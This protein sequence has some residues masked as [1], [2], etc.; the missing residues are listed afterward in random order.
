MKNLMT[1]DRGKAWFMPFDWGNT[2]LIYR[3]DK[4]SEEEAQSLRIF[5]DPKFRDRV[6][7]GDN[8]D[9]AYALASLVHRA[10]GLDRDDRCAVR[11]GIGLPARGAQERA[12]LLDR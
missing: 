8:V 9:D 10:Q 5:A 12:R 1:D 7:I 11:R 3:T 2:A 6:S 4:V